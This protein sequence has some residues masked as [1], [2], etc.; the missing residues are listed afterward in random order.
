MT[1][2]D[3]SDR[4]SRLKSQCAPQAVMLPLKDAPRSL[5]EPVRANWR[6]VLGLVLGLILV[7]LAF[8][9]RVDTQVVMAPG[10]NAKPAHYLT[11][12]GFAL[13]FHLILF[14]L[15]IVALAHQFKNMFLNV[16]VF[17]MLVGYGLASALFAL[18]RG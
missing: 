14:A 4:V 12:M 1:N 3:F 2:A 18:A 5:P 8:A 10:I 13:G 9:A 6:L 16:V 15:I 17:E 11:A 7:P